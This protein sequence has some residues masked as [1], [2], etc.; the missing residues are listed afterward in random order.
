MDFQVQHFFL[1]LSLY[2]PSFRNILFNFYLNSSNFDTNLIPFNHLATKW[3]IQRAAA[4]GLQPS[5]ASSLRRF[6]RRVDPRNFFMSSGQLRGRVTRDKAE[7][8]LLEIRRIEL[9]STITVRHPAVIVAAGCRSRAEARIWPGTIAY[10]TCN[11]IS[12]EYRPRLV[13]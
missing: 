5:K 11:L 4:R 1:P 13:W 10:R 6:H 12:C 3:T 9:S 8:G 7:H 2:F